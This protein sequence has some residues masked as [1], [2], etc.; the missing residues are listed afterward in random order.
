[1]APKPPPA[2]RD[3]HPSIAAALRPIL[4]L[5]VPLLAPMVAAELK[6]QD[7][8]EDAGDPWVDQR[9][10]PLGRRAHCRLC[11]S[12]ALPARKLRRRW[13]VRASDLAAYIEAH[14]RPAAPLTEPANDCH[15]PAEDEPSDADVAAVLASVGRAYVPRRG[16]RS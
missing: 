11:K 14:G 12:G 8:G 9:T 3:L 5:V 10:S 1:V 13:L 4:A 6:A 15:G 16:A 7:A 2:T